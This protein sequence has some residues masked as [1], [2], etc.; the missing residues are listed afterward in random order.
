MSRKSIFMTLFVLAMSV[1]VSYAADP[2]MQSSGPDGI[3][4]MEAEHFHT[5]VAASNRSWEL[6]GPKGG[7]KGAAGMQALPDAGTNINTGYVTTSP[8][9][10]FE[11]AFQKTGTYHVWV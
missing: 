3:V 5:N 11:V 8:H 4:A 7:F 9:L 2:F 6:V 1:G 10:D